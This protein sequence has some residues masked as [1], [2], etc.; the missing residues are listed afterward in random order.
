MELLLSINPIIHYS[1]HWTGLRGE[2]EKKHMKHC[3]RATSDERATG[4]GWEANEG[5]EEDM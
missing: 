1:K 5:P 2:E 3:F 4:Q